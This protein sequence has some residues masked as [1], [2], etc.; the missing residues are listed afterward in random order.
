MK[1]LKRNAL[2]VS[3]IPNS[4]KWHRYSGYF[5]ALSMI[6]HIAALRLLPIYA[7]GYKKASI[8]DVTLAT[9]A[10]KLWP[11]LFFPY[12]ILLITTGIYHTFYGLYYA[13]F[14]LRK[15]RWFSWNSSVWRNLAII[16]FTI[17]IIS[18]AGACGFLFKIDMPL[19][20]TWQSIFD[21]IKP[22]FLKKS[23]KN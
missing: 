1:I 17:G 21:A 10:Y 19:Q 3:S 13:N 16:S 23:I 8:V 6:G 20:D 22:A 7:L 4:R 12:Y 11:Y 5:L 15:K 14:V 9:Y 2:F 18:T